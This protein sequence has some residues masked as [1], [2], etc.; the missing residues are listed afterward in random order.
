MAHAESN[1]AVEPTLEVAGVT[2]R[3]GDRVAVDDV[4]FSIPPGEIYGLLGPNGAGKT[5]TIK[6]ICGLLQADSGT[7]R[8]AGHQAGTL[9]AK[10]VVGYVLQDVALYPD[11]TGRENLQ[12]PG[13]LFGLRGG[14]LDERVDEALELSDLADRAGEHLSSYSG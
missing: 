3:F 1:V 4:S 12:F 5:T 2:R 7:A 14:V 11:L 6:M 8:V 10:A 13:R 9:A